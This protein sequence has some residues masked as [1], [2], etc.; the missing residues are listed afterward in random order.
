VEEDDVLSRLIYLEKIKIKYPNEPFLAHEIAICYEDLKEWEKYDKAVEENYEKYS[1]YPSI[2]INYVVLNFEKDGSDTLDDVFG[3]ILN[4]HEVYP[5][6]KMFDS[7]VVENFYAILSD[8]YRV[9]N[10]LL[11]AR[12]CAEIVIEFDSFK[13]ILLKNRIDFIEKPWLRWKSR[14]VMGAI[15]LL[16]LSII[17]G[18]IWGIVSLFQWIF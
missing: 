4:I 18:I 3:N 10:E 16:I 5:A 7:K 14:L 1:G 11:I 13:G 12:Q 2:D 9:R 8:I 17:G 15:I 6:Y